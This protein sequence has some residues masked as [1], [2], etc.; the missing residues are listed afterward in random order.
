VAGL[1]RGPVLAIAVTLGA[2]AV[3]AAL[4]PLASPTHVAAADPVATPGTEPARPTCAD[5]FPAEGPAG[6]DLRL[7]CIAGEIVG[8][9]TASSGQPPAPIST[10]V[11]VAAGGVAIAIFAGWLVTR[12]LARRAGRRLAPVLAGSWWVCD[13]CRSVNGAEKVRCYSCGAPPGSGPAM[14]T[15]ERPETPQS[16]GG[17]G[18]R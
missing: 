16:F 5:R 7:G 14:P 18:K 4:T 2:M 8:L 17:Q 15:S 12:T 9:Y 6:V 1:T 10:W 11:L 13:R 3:I